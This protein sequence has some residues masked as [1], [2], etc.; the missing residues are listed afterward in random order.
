MSKFERHCNEPSLRFLAFLPSWLSKQQRSGAPW[1]IPKCS[2]EVKG[3]RSSWASVPICFPESLELPLAPWHGHL[4]VCACMAA[5]APRG[6]RPGRM[7][8]K[9]CQS[10][11]NSAHAAFKSGDRQVRG[12]LAGADQISP[13]SLHIWQR[14]GFGPRYAGHRSPCWRHFV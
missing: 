4:V 3:R 5:S 9:L 12:K 14:P 10:R 1:A 11:A 6:P 8:N 13:K 7:T 2:G